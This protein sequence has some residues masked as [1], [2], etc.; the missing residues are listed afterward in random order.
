MKRIFYLIFAIS[1]LISCVQG[2][3]ELNKRQARQI[4]KM[5]EYKVDSLQKAQQKICYQMV[6]AVAK[7]KADS[8]IMEFEYEAINEALDKPQKPDKPEKPKVEIPEFE[9]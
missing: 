4:Q 2:E 8:I 3:P 5:I 9:E 7:P 1:F 6:L